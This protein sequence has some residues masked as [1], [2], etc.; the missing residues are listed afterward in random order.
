MDEFANKFT[1][2]MLIA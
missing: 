2:S 1:I